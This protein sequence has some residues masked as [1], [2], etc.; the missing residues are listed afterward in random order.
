MEGESMGKLV[1]LLH[2]AQELRLL[3]TEH[4]NAL[5]DRDLAGF[6]EELKTLISPDEIEVALDIIN[7]GTIILEEKLNQIKEFISFLTQKEKILQYLQNMPDDNI[8][9]EKISKIWIS[10]IVVPNI[11]VSYLE[12]SWIRLIGNK[13]TKIKFQ[14]PTKPPQ[15]QTKITTLLKTEEKMFEERL[16]EYL[17]EI[18]SR[19]PAT[20]NIILSSEKNEQVYYEHFSMILYLL[21]EGFITYNPKNAIFSRRKKE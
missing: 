4:P 1:D 17:S 5:L 6:F 18:Q 2:Q 3:S 15:I 7:D 21:Q 12:D 10:P 19:L 8:L 16:M 11:A 20:L 13:S 14:L 9:T